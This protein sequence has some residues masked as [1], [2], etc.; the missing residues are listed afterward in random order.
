MLA[1]SMHFVYHGF[2]RLMYQKV[3]D[4]R[5]E[6]SMT[7]L[8]GPV[9]TGKFLFACSLSSVVLLATWINSRSV[10]AADAPQPV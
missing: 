8:L 3:S 2:H 10:T 5:A 6:T 1:F 4:N 7:K 9:P